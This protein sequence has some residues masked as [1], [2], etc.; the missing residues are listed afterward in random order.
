MPAHIAMLGTY[1]YA[2]PYCAVPD[3]YGQGHVDV[4]AY[5][6]HSETQAQDEG[7]EDDVDAA[8]PVW[9]QQLGR[10]LGCCCCCC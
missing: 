10:R 3:R 2:C 8:L 9:I 5:D 7:N 1:R 4:D 6:G